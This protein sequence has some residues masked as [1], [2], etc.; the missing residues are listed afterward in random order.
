MTTKEEVL[1]ACKVDGLVVKLP[2]TQLDRKLYQEVAKALELIGGKWKGGKVQGFVFTLDPTDLLDTIANGGKRNLKKE[3]QFFATPSELAHELVQYA[4][5]KNTDS[6]LEPSCGQGAII[7]H[8]NKAVPNVVPDCYELM[9]INRAI[10][11]KKGLQYNLVGEDFLSCDKKY[12]K[13]IANP[14]FA[15]DQDMKHIQHMFKC[16]RKGGRLVSLATEK[17]FTNEDNDAQ[18][19]R[20]LIFEEWLDAVDAEILHVPAGTF[21]ESGTNVGACIIIIDRK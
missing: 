4:D 1:Q 19:Q 21:K 11:A 8:I 2:D 6:V 3:F 16:L 15:K 18:A 20:Y 10:L 7:E 17:F 12:D 14:P 13:I 9:D 5:L